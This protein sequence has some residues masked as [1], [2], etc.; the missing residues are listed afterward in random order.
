MV[1]HDSEVKYLAWSNICAIPVQN[2]DSAYTA[3]FP[4]DD[5]VPKNNPNINLK[6][7]LNCHA[8][9]L[10]LRDPGLVP[11]AEQPFQESPG[12]AT[13]RTEQ[14]QKHVRDEPEKAAG[15]RRSG[16]CTF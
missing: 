2:C 14:P 5:F 11:G 15:S 1:D 9:P 4:V 6:T 10:Q 13:G 12:R 8:G 7:V 3:K 16:T